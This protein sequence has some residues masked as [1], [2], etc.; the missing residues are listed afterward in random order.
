MS[1]RA[2]SVFGRHVITESEIEQEIERQA[3]GR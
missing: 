3:G 2:F 1:G